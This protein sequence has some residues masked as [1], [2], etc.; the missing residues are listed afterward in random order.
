M[1]VFMRALSIA[2]KL[3]GAIIGGLAI[4]T[5]IGVFVGR[6]TI[7]RQWSQPPLVLSPANVTRSSAGDA[8]PTPKAGTTVLRAMPIG[9]ARA[10]LEPMTAKDPVVATVVSIGSGDEGMEL[11]V[12]V[13][14]RGTCKVTS[15]SGVAYGFDAKGRSSAINKNGDHYAAFA[16]TKLSLAPRAHTMVAQ[17]L[18]YADEATLGV[19]HIDEMT[20][21]DGTSWK[22]H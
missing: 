11:H 19:A 17:K 7:E 4:G 12:V 9:R 1:R 13:E 2:L 6:W 14:N 20:C 16:G 18:R 8:D 21:S 3:L 10:A 22:R 15:L 5:T